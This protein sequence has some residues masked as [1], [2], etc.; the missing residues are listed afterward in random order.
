MIKNKC[1]KCD[2]LDSVLEQKI[3]TSGKTGET[4]K[5]KIWALVDRNLLILG[6][7]VLTNVQLYCKR[8]TPQEMELDMRY[9]ENSVLFIFI[10][11]LAL[12]LQLFC[13]YKIISK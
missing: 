5:K 13:K 9:L 3:D 7:L 1:K 11:V 8:I 2:I 4:E 10:S 12:S 6:F